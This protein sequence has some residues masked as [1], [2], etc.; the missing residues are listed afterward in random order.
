MADEFEDMDNSSKMV[1][2]LRSL[3][4]ENKNLKEENEHV[5]KELESE[6]VYDKRVSGTT[7]NIKS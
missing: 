6:K 2:Q 7:S 3:E 4:A 5:N 1:S